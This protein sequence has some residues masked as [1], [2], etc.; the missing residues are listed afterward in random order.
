MGIFKSES[1]FQVWE[2]QRKSRN[3]ANLAAQPIGEPCDKESELHAQIMS[4]CKAE[5]WIALHSAWG[6]KTGRLPGEPDFTVV[7]PDGAV[8]FV[9]CKKGNEKLTIEQCGV[10]AWLA[11]LGHTL[12]VVRNVTE[13]MAAIETERTAARKQKSLAANLAARIV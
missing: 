13:F 7:L 3:L 9:E 1:E 6:K 12:H 5:M 2:I 10:E 11:K 4:I 8:C